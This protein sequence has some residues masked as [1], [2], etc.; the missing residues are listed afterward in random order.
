MCQS[1]VQLFTHRCVV[2]DDDSVHCSPSL[3]ETTKSDDCITAML[4][5]LDP[6]AVSL[7]VCL[8]PC[9]CTPPHATV[10]GCVQSNSRHETKRGRTC[11]S[12]KSR[13]WRSFAAYCAQPETPSSS[14]TYAE[15]SKRSIPL[16]IYDKLSIHM[17]TLELKLQR[18]RVR[19]R[20]CAPARA[21]ERE[22]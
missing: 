15:S 10:D 6:P 17:I 12:S 21:R 3:S 2:Y 7:S 11:C 5:H 18:E 20:A 8:K 13:S 9:L 16:M 1:P 14:C 22:R 19:P 4:H